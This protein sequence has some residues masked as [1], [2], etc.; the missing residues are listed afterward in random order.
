MTGHI[1]GMLRALPESQERGNS[2][3]V[4]VCRDVISGKQREVMRMNN[5]SLTRLSRDHHQ[6]MVEK[7][8]WEGRPDLSAKHMLVITELSKAVEAHRA[9]KWCRW[10]PSELTDIMDTTN[11]STHDHRALATIYNSTV[12]G[13]VEEEV[14]DATLRLLDLAGYHGYE[15]GQ[16][17]ADALRAPWHEVFGK[18]P[19]LPGKLY[20]V[21][22]NIGIDIHMAITG[23]ELVCACHKIN[24][25]W[26][27]DAKMRYNETREYRHGKAY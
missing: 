8:F 19:T 25:W 20:H 15:F 26:H 9:R 10:I 11:M 13:T 18:E 17:E 27:V 1:R 24:L 23:I 16:W 7:G 3:C 14:A 21:S 4:A 6:K 2:I 22:K 12:K 5:E